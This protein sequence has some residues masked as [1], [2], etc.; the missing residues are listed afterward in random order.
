MKTMKILVAGAN[1][2]LGRSLL[3]LEGEAEWVGCGRRAEAGATPYHQVELTDRAEVAGLIA[4]TRP[5]WVI[6]AAAMTNVDQC[7]KDPSAAR[8]ANVEIVENLVAAC[9]DADVGLLQ[10][11]TDYVFDGESGP[12]A[13]GA[14]T[15]PLSR[16]GQLKLE[17]ESALE[18]LQRAVVVRT[19]WLYG[20]VPETGANFITWLLQTL[21]NGESVRVFDDQWG[22]PTYV[23][24][25]AR[26]LVALCREE[27]GGLF[28]MGGATFMTRYELALELATFFGLDSG[29]IEP[30]PTGEAGLLAVR[31][32]RSGLR[33]DRLE[34]V[35]G[36]RP[37][38]FA[39]G[40]QHLI[41]DTHFQR[42]FPQFAR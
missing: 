34:A 17:S 18:G 36:R 20:Y 42:D 15:K 8:Q 9:S 23:H 14:G 29:L 3:A 5:D 28:H 25:L 4:K 7:E 41:R 27:A 26:S 6:N 38:G 16:Y 33:T 31:P 39:E 32:L 22:N 12:Y 35:L 40:L 24:D 10:I 11:S 13:E 2:F 1:G 37:L 19:L 21:S 30:V